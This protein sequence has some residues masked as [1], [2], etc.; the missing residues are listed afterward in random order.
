[1]N[2]YSAIRGE[3]APLAWG[4]GTI[5]SHRHPL[6]WGRVVAWGLCLDPEGVRRPALVAGAVSRGQ[7][8]SLPPLTVS[9]S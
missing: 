8:M 9:N 5:S 6:L 3:L 7:M 2:F 4:W 1:M